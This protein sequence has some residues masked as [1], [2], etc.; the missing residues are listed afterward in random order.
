MAYDFDVVSKLFAYQD[1]KNLL[2]KEYRIY[3]LILF[4]SIFFDSFQYINLVLLLIISKY[5]MSF[6]AI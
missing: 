2:I 6:D 1:H 3:L 4:L 5:F